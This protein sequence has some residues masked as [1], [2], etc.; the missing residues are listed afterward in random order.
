MFQRPNLQARQTKHSRACIY[1]VVRSRRTSR[2]PTPARSLPGDEWLATLSSRCSWAAA[3]SSQCA[4]GSRC[5]RP[6]FRNVLGKVPTNYNSKHKK[7]FLYAVCLLG[8]S[9]FFL[10]ERSSERSRCERITNLRFTGFLVCT[11]RFL[12]TSTCWSSAFVC[13]CFSSVQCL[14]RTKRDIS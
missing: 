8:I 2:R 14:A 7:V 3:R 5:C 10:C 13:E 6:S 9:T 12:G 1:P 11:A 4:R